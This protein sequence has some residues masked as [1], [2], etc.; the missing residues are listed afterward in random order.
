MENQDVSKAAEFCASEL[1]KENESL[2]LIF[3]EGLKVRLQEAFI[4][5]YFRGQRDLLNSKAKLY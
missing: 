2:M 1:L 3:N 5:G 4:K